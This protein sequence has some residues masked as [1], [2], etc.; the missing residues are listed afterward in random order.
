MPLITLDALPVREIFPGVRARLIHTDRVSHS[1]VDLDEGATFPEHRHPH[2]QIVSVL[3]G[4]LEIVVAGERFVLTPGQ[5]FVIP[6]DTPHAGRALTP[7]RVLDAFAPVR[8]D[9]R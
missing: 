9:Y 6:P 7:C 4:E 5:V 1:W 2:E 3:D 8:E